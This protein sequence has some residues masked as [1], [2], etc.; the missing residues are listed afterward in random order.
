MADGTIVVANST[1]VAE[2]SYT[3]F[4]VASGSPPVASGSLGNVPAGSHASGYP[5][6]QTCQVS[7]YDMYSVAFYSFGGN[8]STGYVQ[9]KVGQRVTLS[10]QIS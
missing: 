9:A 3:I 6:Q 10:A 4:G 8:P 2:L 1:N 7:G 5:A